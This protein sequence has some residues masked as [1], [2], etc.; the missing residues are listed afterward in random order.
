MGIL[1]ESRHDVLHKVLH[2]A[3]LRGGQLDL[4]PRYNIIGSGGAGGGAAV[5]EVCH[6]VQGALHTCNLS[7]SSLAVSMIARESKMLCLISVVEKSASGGSPGIFSLTAG[8]TGYLEAASRPT[9]FLPGM[10]TI[11][12]WKERVFSFSFLSLL[13]SMS[14]RHLSLRMP[15]NGL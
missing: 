6:G 3:V 9:C 5:V 15:S 2:F 14:A 13:F 7:M 12:N 1:R 4:V 11:L 8:P 10:W